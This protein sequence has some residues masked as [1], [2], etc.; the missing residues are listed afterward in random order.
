MDRPLLARPEPGPWSTD[1]CGR[2]RQPA[3]FELGGPRVEPLRQLDGTDPVVGLVVV[4]VAADL[5]RDAARRVG[6]LEEVAHWLLP[7]FLT[8]RER[9][10]RMPGDSRLPEKNV[11]T[12]HDRT[13]V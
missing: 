7:V 6:L 4:D 1:R 11:G 3:V 13:A 10:L 5:V 2:Q 9:P 12:L 8:K